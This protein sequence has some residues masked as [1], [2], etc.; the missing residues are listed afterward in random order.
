MT[1]LDTLIRQCATVLE[2]T[3]DAVLTLRADV[4]LIHLEALR[5]CNAELPHYDIGDLLHHN[6]SLVKVYGVTKAANKRDRFWYRV[7]SRNG[8]MQEVRES[9]LARTNGRV[10]HG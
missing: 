6:G 9:A 3:P 5:A 10:K 4:L 7:G 1:T 8:P 2:Q